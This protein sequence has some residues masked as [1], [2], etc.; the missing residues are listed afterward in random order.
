M[1]STH[2]HAHVEGCY[3]RQFTIRGYIYT[4]IPEDTRYSLIVWLQHNKYKS[5]WE[6]IS[7]DYDS[8]CGGHFDNEII[9]LFIREFLAHFLV[10]KKIFVCVFV[11]YFLYYFMCLALKVNLI[12][13]YCAKFIFKIIS[14]E[15]LFPLISDDY[16]KSAIFLIISPT[17]KWLLINS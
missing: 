11:Y 12:K 8:L 17:K 16:I 15:F 10:F 2:M 1:V 7:C 14:Y 5:K 3:I 6:S 13:K 9:Y 4:Q